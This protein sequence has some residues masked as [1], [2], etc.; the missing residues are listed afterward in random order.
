MLDLHSP[1][2]G[3]VDLAKS[4]GVSAARVGT[5]RDFERVLGAAIAGRGPCLIEAVID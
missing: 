1:V 5:R 4:L 3:W 2:I